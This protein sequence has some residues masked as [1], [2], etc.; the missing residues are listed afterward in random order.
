MSE[1]SSAK[2]RTTPSGIKVG[3]RSLVVACALWPVSLL[4]PSLWAQTSLVPYDQVYGPLFHVGSSSYLYP[5]RYRS[6]RDVDFRNLTVSFWKDENGKPR[7]FHLRNGEC[8]VD[9]DHHLLHTSVQLVGLHYLS[10]AET[11]REHALVL[12]EEDDVGG[13]SSQGGV[14]QVFELASKRLRVVQ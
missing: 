2:P 9:F 1:P 8:K 10:S 7:L 14:A 4:V 12:Y 3:T 5:S 11:G 13:S 6:I